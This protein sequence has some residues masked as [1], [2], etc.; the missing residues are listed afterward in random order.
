MIVPRFVYCTSLHL[1]FQGLA[2]VSAWKDHDRSTI[3]CCRFTTRVSGF[4]CGGSWF[5]TKLRSISIGGTAVASATFL[6]PG[7]V[8]LPMAFDAP[9]SESDPRVYISLIGM[10]TLPCSLALDVLLWHFAGWMMWRCKE[11]TWVAYWPCPLSTCSWWLCGHEPVINLARGIWRMPPENSNYSI[12]TQKLVQRAVSE[13]FKSESL[14]W[15]PFRPFAD[16]KNCTSLHLDLGWLWVNVAS[17]GLQSIPYI[18]SLVSTFLQEFEG[19]PSP[20]PYTSFVAEDMS[21]TLSWEN[22]QKKTRPLLN[23]SALSSWQ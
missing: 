13:S 10:I 6:L 21:W 17:R 14:L 5:P 23:C 15:K 16:K 8:M 18:D 4:R 2:R 12:Q 20:L 3:N 7:L 1:Y 9:G 19:M 11:V 22:L